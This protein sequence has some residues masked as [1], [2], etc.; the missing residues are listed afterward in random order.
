MITFQT[1]IP[2][3]RALRLRHLMQ[4]GD[5]L[6]DSTAVDRFH[7]AVAIFIVR[8][9]GAVEEQP[10]VDLHA[11]IAGAW[12]QALH[13]GPG[14]GNRHE[15]E[16]LARLRIQRTQQRDKTIIGD[17]ASL[18]ICTGRSIV[19][20]KPCGCS[21]TVSRLRLLLISSPRPP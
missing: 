15:L 6:Q 18:K 5:I 8:R 1:Q 16:S 2:P 19:I 10:G 13:V 20:R 17:S 4:H 21:S 11:Q 7:L 12:R 9:F 14:V 3:S